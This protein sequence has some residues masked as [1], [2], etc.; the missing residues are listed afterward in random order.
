MKVRFTVVLAAVL[1]AVLLLP[2]LDGCKKI[3]ERLSRFYF[4][5]RRGH[6]GLVEFTERRFHA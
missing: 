4:V 2:H 1:M 6:G 5:Q 3:I